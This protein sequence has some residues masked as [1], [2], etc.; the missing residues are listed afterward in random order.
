MLTNIYIENVAV[1]EKAS[2]DFDEAFNILTGETGAGKS[3][4]IDSINAIMGQRMSRD[5]IR[6]G[7]KQAFISATFSD[8]TKAAVSKLLE[9][10]FEDEDG[11][12]ILQR[13]ITAAGKNICRIN[14]RPATL[15]VLREV[16][17][18]L[19]N[20]YGQNEGYDFMTADSHIKYI[21][22][23][24][25][26]HDLLE[27]YKNK[28]KVYSDLKHR[29]GEMTGNIQD[30]ERKID[31]LKYQIDEIDDAELE[32][33]EQE[34]LESR[35][36]FLNNGERI[37]NGV[38]MSYAA[39]TGDDDGSE[40]ILSRLEEI[41]DELSDLSRLHPE[42]EEL[43]ERIQSAYEEI[44]DCHYELRNIYDDLDYDPEEIEEVEERLD[45]IRTLS[46]KYGN[47]IE[48]ILEFCENAREEL[49]SLLQFDIN[50]EKLEEEFK[51]A[52]EQLKRSANQLSKAR[53]EAAEKFATAVMKEMKYLDMPN[54]VM[55]PSITKCGFTENGCD[56]LE[57]LISANP[58]EEPKPISK[59]A[60][61][62]ELSRIM[63]A[64]KT[65]IAEKDEIDTLIFDEVDTGI[66]GS[67]ASKVGRKLLELSGS[68]Q[69][70]CITHQAQIAALADVHLFISKSVS[71][72][73]TFTSV[74]RLDFEERKYELSRIIDGSEP[75]ELSLQHAEEM[76]KAR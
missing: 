68:H 39:L 62:G 18:F 2:I 22:A 10:G 65:I 33:G 30:R 7:E 40:G 45:L 23:I 12:Y 32:P 69:V 24:G 51:K 50:K 37:K 66:S 56:L 73:R 38:A 6:S 52:E 27:D 74:K 5:L 61:G 17:I 35:R 1:I 72:G 63:L 44:N 59:I 16:S 60:S 67:A 11:D 26:Y 20:I 57:L 53:A 8:V 21:D 70:I 71:G 64:V 15:S 25:A 75:S 9:L 54:V 31:L 48:E 41:G 14:G 46:R 13:T 55:V 76:L 43:A 4:I 47:T 34:E 28:F 36:S 3:I 49:N 58:G 42:L 19:I 29:L